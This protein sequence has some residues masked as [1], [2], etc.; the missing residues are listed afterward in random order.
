MP[1]LCFSKRLNFLILGRTHLVDL[2]AL[3]LFFGAK[4]RLA[5]EFDLLLI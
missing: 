4:S 1:F 5:L 3:L 2:F